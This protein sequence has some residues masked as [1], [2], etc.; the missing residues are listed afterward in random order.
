M[1]DKTN[2]NGEKQMLIGNVKA[3][4]HY[5]AKHTEC[6]FLSKFEDETLCVEIPDLM[7]IIQR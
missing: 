4:I 3:Y 7:H 1:N 5:D 2:S 6:S